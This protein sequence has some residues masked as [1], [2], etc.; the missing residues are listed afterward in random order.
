MD[1]NQKEKDSKPTLVARPSLVGNPAASPA[2]AALDP[3][4]TLLTE[5]F[6][7]RANP[8][9]DEIIRTMARLAN[10]INLYAAEALRSRVVTAANP[11]TQA[12]LNA[13]GNLENGAVAQRQELVMKAAQAS[14]QF[15]GPGG[16]GPGAPP[17][18]MN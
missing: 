8:T 4:D 13:A 3:R 17:F 9:I 10:F 14:G 15:V 6:E 12:M 18:R 1:D 11:S 7:T 2:S 16:P 5:T